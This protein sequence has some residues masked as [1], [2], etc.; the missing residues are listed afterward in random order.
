MNIYLYLDSEGKKDIKS[1]FSDCYQIDINILKA[2]SNYNLLN[3]KITRTLLNNSIDIEISR[4]NKSRKYT[5]LIIYNSTLSSID[6]L[7]HF[8]D[9]KFKDYTLNL[10]DINCKYSKFYDKIDQVFNNI[11]D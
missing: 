4:F 5:D 2:K 7:I 3:N 1:K 9:S 8:L 10:I 11:T 6:N